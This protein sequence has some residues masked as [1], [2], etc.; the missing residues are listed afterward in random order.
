GIA[1]AQFWRTLGEPWLTPRQWL[2]VRRFDD[3]GRAALL[4]LGF[5]LL[6]GTAPFLLPW[7]AVLAALPVVLWMATELAGA[8]RPA[9]AVVFGVLVGCSAFVLDILMLGYA[10]AGFQLVALLALAAFSTYAALAR[11]T[12][13]GLAAR[14]VATA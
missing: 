13:R 6:G 8:G 12:L 4:G 14:A 10:A 1:P 5:R 3:S 9:A 11:P 7:L 2:V